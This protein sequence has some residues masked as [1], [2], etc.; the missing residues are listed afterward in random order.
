[1]INTVKDFINYRST[2]P[3]C[4]KNLSL[5]FKGK[6]RKFVRY[7]N[8]RV[9][10]KKD[11]Y[12]INKKKTY[13]FIYSI[14]MNDNT[15]YIDFSNA[16]GEILSDSIP[17]SYIQGFNLYNKSNTGV[18]YR[19]CSNCCSYNYNTNYFNVDMKRSKLEKFHL[20]NEYISTYKKIGENNYRVYRINN[21]YENDTS[22]IDWFHTDDDG[23]SSRSGMEW[24]H[25]CYTN[26]NTLNVN[27]QK[28]DDIDNLVNRLD[29]LIVFS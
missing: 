28:I 2:C 3:L 19:F 27:I 24:D 12:A 6:T 10:I 13:S 1:M 8:D 29:K 23:L 5:A 22:I 9:L 26:I 17:I 11:M 14:D 20:A 7:E 25:M 21:Q 16:K 4:S 18:F 15:F